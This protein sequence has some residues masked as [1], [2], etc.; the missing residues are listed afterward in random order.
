MPQ[1]KKAKATKVKAELITQ[2]QIDK[3][4]Q[5]MEKPQAGYS[6]KYSDE[7]KI[8]ALALRA[9]NLSYPKISDLTGVPQGTLFQW[10][11]YDTFS[12]EFNDAVSEVAEKI[13]KG[14]KDRLIANANRSFI[15]AM[16][17]E[18]MEKASYWDLVRGGATM[19]DKARLLGGESTENVAHLSKKVV[20]SKG[21]DSN[22]DADI[23]KIDAEIAMLR[24]GTS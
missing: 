11:K 10:C 16:S 12:D 14:F 20:E 7:I 23:T 17:E 22:L 4:I 1:K 13:N 6:T 15:S 18:K 2:D 9:N 8:Q 24:E 3:A 21:K 19:I 5:V